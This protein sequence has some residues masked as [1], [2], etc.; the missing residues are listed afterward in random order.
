MR[1]TGNN[2]DWEF[3]TY[4]KDSGSL[5]I[6]LHISTWRFPWLKTPEG[7]QSFIDALRKEDVLLVTC[8]SSTF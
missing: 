7:F 4:E 2:F 3:G 1:L 6:G 8:Q 5:P